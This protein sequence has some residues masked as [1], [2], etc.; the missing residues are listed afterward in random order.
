MPAYPRFSAVVDAQ[1]K[2]RF[3]NRLAFDSWVSTMATK[4]VEVSIRPWQKTR[5][6]AQNATWWGLVLETLSE[7]NGDEPEV[8]HRRLKRHFQIKSTARLTTREFEELRERVARWAAETHGVVIPDP[9][10]ISL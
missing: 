7:W 8:W 1:G 3:D 2:V 9:N 5:T 6:L 4:H 10:E